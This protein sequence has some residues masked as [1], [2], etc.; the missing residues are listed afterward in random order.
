M[1]PGAS[2]PISCLINN[3]KGN[4]PRNCQVHVK[5]IRKQ[6]LLSTNLRKPIGK[7]IFPN[8]DLQK[9]IGKP[10]FLDSDLQKP[11]GEHICFNADI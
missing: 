8:S 10:V 4:S 6:I 2:K 9:P 1:A 11:I 3:S 5:P 7:Q